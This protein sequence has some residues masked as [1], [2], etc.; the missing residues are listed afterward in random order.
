MFKFRFL[1]MNDGFTQTTFR[2]D[3]VHFVTPLKLQRKIYTFWLK[4]RF[5]KKVLNQALPLVDSKLLN[6]RIISKKFLSFCILWV[7][8][9]KNYFVLYHVTLVGQ[10][11]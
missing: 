8:E 7:C 4:H 10:Y 11:Y 9:V 2:C 5:C 1:M 3:L 6:S